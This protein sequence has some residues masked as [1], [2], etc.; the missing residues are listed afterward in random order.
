MLK[1]K[2]MAEAWKL[3]GQIFPTD[4]EKD[5]ERSKGAGYP[6]YSSTEVGR[7]YDYI[8]DLNDRLEINLSDG[9]RTVN[10]WIDQTV[11]DQKTEGA[12]LLK[13]TEAIKAAK[14]LGKEANLLFAPEQYTEITLVV[15]GSKWNCNTTEKSVYDGLKREESW[16]AGDLIASYCENHGIRW[17]TIKDV[18]YQYYEHGKNS[19]NGGHFIVTG[20]ISKRADEEVRN[21]V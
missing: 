3:A 17:G 13:S 8:C 16:L 2:N 15:D 6:I 9:N 11:A 5:V 14:E 21:A 7:N 1:V 10:I 19:E 20:Y 18:K 12:A 4:Y